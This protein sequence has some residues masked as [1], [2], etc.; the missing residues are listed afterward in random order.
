MS[1]P[2]FNVPY[3]RPTR[4][5]DPFFD[6]DEISCNKILATP[7]SKLVWH[8][9]QN[10]LGPH[11]PAGT[12]EEVVYF[13]PGAFGFVLH[14][15]EGTSDVMTALIGFTSINA[16]RL[17]EDGLLDVV[18]LHLSKCLREWT[19]TFQVQHRNRMTSLAKTQFRRVNDYV[20][21]S[22]LV[23]EAIDDLVKFQAHQDLAYEFAKSLAHHADDPMKAAWFLEIAAGQHEHHMCKDFAIRDLLRNRELLKSAADVVLKHLFENEPSPTYWNDTF[24]ILGL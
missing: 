22:E 23:C 16:D 4:L 24:E 7:D 9:Y 11:L 13:L 1:Q 17:Q 18:R 15:N 21:R 2:L 12:Y 20:S 3:R 6:H 8:D 19:L 14:D 10:L 5:S